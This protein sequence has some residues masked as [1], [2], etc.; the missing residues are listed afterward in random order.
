MPFIEFSFLKIGGA[1]E[2]DRTSMAKYLPKRLRALYRSGRV[3]TIDRVTSSNCAIN[4]IEG[5]C[6]ERDDFHHVLTGGSRQ[7][8]RELTVRADVTLDKDLKR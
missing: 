6:H 8:Q 5:Q 1:A 3:R 2:C 4:E 7:P